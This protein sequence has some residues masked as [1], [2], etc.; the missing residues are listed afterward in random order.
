MLGNL[1]LYSLPIFEEVHILSLNI[2]HE[3]I[4]GLLL[5]EHDSLHV[6]YFLLDHIVKVFLRVLDS[7]EALVEV[8]I[9]LFHCC[10]IDFLE[11]GQVLLDVV[12]PHISV[13]NLVHE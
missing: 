1:Q 4:N 6:I 9:L 13:L 2:V 10:F 3:R 8:S 11:F 7:G 12:D 5:L